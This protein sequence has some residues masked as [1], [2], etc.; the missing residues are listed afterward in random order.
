M[1]VIQVPFG[2]H[3]DPVGG[4][5]VYVEMLARGLIASNID[6]VIAAPAATG[7]SYEHDRLRVRRFAATERL[8]D[9]GDLY[10]SGDEG[11]ARQ[12]G[13]IVDEERPDLVHLHALSP[14]ASL[15]LV[16]E[17]KRRRVPM[18]FT[19]HT[20]TVSCQRGTL[21]RWGEQVCDGLLDVRTCASCTLHG[22]GLPRLPSEL[23]G[24]IPA[25]VGRALGAARLS[26]GAWTAL[27]MS[28][29]T[30]HRQDS[31]R[32]FLTEVDAIV[33]LCRWAEELL[34][35]NGVARDRVT[36]S[37]HGV[38]DPVATAPNER[39]PGPIRVAF[40]GRL[41]PTKGPDLLVRAM[42]SLPEADL[43]LHVY[44]IVQEGLGGSYLEELRRLAAGDPRIEF[45]PAIAKDKVVATLRRYHALAVPSRLLETGPLVVLEAFASGI[46]V[47]GARLG[48]IA[49][50]VTHERD[51]LLVAA[52]SVS[53]WRA[54]LLRLSAERALPE[55]LAAGVR[56]PRLIGDV[57]REMM[58]LYRSISSG[59][60]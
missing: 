38:S 32:A 11:A 59:V 40:L 39:S 57:V 18:V 45:L 30:A 41:D 21:L 46:P 33:V 43:E 9:L 12:F 52:D 15:R 26:G 29:L 23:L 24:L 20:P 60:S 47:L 48:G 5:E 37:R 1:K 58:T 10:G 36:L 50:L 49:E 53:E 4:T 55:R 22:L 44:G 6:T 56:P 25:T 27:R 2:F 3:P 7:A 8:R 16:R 17:V 51:G 14:A 19:Y 54:T 42:R 35:L 13:S 28:E 34:I 31:L